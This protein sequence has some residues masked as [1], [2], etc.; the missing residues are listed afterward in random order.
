MIT[1]YTR[2]LLMQSSPD[3][4]SLLR[5]DFTRE[6]AVALDHAALQ[7]GAPNEPT[8]LRNQGISTTGDSTLNWDNVIDAITEVEIANAVPGGW[9]ISPYS[10]R[11]LMK[12]VRQSGGVEGNF[13]MNDPNSLGGLP[14]Y[15]SM[16]LRDSG[17]PEEELAIVGEWSN[18]LIGY[19]GGLDFLLNPYELTAYPKG[20]V[21]IRALL[22]ADVAVRHAAAFCQIA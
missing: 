1:E 16:V 21:Q 11:T 3:V 13:V 14:A 15:S 20:N 7:G 8:G 6:L 22:S 17:S 9:A 19:F 2:Q 18:L 4:E 5:A 12:A 10:K